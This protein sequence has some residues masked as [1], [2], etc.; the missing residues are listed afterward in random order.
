MPWMLWCLCFFILCIFIKRSI[1]TIDQHAYFY[2]QPS[3]SLGPFVV[4]SESIHTIWVDTI[5]PWVN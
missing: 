4:H 2:P 1:V 3:P 5:F